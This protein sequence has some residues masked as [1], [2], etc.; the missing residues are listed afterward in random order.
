MTG[1][2]ARRFTRGL[3]AYDVAGVVLDD[4]AIQVQGLVPLLGSAGFRKARSF[5]GY[6][7]WLRAR[8]GTK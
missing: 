5:T 8:V 4:A 2:R 7:V 6:E 1:W 3:E